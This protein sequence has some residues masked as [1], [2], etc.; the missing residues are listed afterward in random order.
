[1]FCGIHINYAKGFVQYCS[2]KYVNNSDSFR[3]G[4]LIKYSAYCNTKTYDFLFNKDFSW[5]FSKPG[6]QVCS[7]TIRSI[8]GRRRSVIA[9]IRV[10]LD[11]VGVR[12]D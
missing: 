1:M 6:T 7:R 11:V 10:S 5:R 3:L 8:I 2:T 4:H 12:K 9:G